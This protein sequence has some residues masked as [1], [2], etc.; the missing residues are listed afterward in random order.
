M[1][2]ILVMALVWLI[3]VGFVLTL[4]RAAAMGDRVE[5]HRRRARM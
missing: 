2:V 5:E 4:L 1:H 3:L